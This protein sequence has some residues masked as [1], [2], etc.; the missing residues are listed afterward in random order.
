MCTVFAVLVLK[1]C[2]LHPDYISRPRKH[3]DP[4]SCNEVR[5]LEIA[6]EKDSSVDPISLAKCTGILLLD[7]G[8]VEGWKELLEDDEE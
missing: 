2:V 3:E 7:L 8:E 1:G 5:N 6:S 4:K